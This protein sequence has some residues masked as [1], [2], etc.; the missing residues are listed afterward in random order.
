MIPIVHAQPGT[1]EANYTQAQMVDRST[2]E[3]TIG[4]WKARFRC[5]GK[6]RV[7]EYTPVKAGKIANACAALHNI[8]VRAGLPLVDEDDEDEED[9]GAENGDRELGAQLPA[10]HV[11]IAGEAV[12]RRLVARIPLLPPR[13]PFNPVRRHRRM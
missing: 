2:V 4:Q 12:R 11:R 5:M 6:D 7:L 8:C 9:N 13:A 3:R 10:R 1:P